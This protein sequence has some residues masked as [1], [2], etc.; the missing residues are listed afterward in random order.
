MVR[1]IVKVFVLIV[2]FALPSARQ[3]FAAEAAAVRLSTFRC[4]ATTPLDGRS[5]GGWAQPLTK[6]EDPLW[7]KG[8]V[9]DD[10]RKRYVV[11]AMDWCQLRD[12]TYLL[13]CHKIAAAAGIDASRVAIQCLHQHTAPVGDGD[14]AA[15][16]SGDRAFAAT[17]TSKRSKS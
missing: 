11:C 13:F 5:F 4:D 15:D 6:L 12:S 9:L 3:T 1:S 16:P 14:A 7:A 10:G 17:R 8:I 2:C